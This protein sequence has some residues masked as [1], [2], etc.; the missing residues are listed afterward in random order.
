MYLV[1]AR[2]NQQIAQEKLHFSHRSVAE[3]RTESRGF[4]LTSGVAVCNGFGSSGFG[5]GFPQKQDEISLSKK[6]QTIPSF[7]GK[8]CESEGPSPKCA[9]PTP[10]YSVSRDM[11]LSRSMQSE[12]KRPKNW[13]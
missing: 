13:I 5:P 9:W 8:G 3:G 2:E 1:Q 11:T 4:D 12:I 6:I 10:D 7:D